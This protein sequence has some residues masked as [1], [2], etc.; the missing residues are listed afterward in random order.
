MKDVEQRDL[1]PEYLRKKIE[2]IGLLYTSRV[3]SQLVPA[4]WTATWD[5]KSSHYRYENMVCEYLAFVLYFPLSVFLDFRL[6][7]IAIPSSLQS[8]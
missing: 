7:E 4:G 1:P 6:L 8:C 3:E 5:D 2:E